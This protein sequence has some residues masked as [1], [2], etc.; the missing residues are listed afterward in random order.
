MDGLWVECL[1][2][3]NKVGDC[4]LSW[5][6]GFM[7]YPSLIRYCF[8]VI[9]SCMAFMPSFGTRS[10]SVKPTGHARFSVELYRLI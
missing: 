3:V 8:I 1:H 10:D 9:E 4:G 2:V 6:W 5:L 7:I